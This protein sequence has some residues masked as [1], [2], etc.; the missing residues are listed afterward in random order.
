M[1]G[2]C[3]KISSIAR[4]P[5]LRERF[6]ALS[7]E[8]QVIRGD[9]EESASHDDELV[10]FFLDVPDNEENHAFFTEAKERLAQRFEQ[11]EIW[12]T[13]FPVERL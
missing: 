13:S 10:R 12:I 4:A 2:R 9:A 6:G 8:S 1:A 11:V 5:E 3:R 7:A